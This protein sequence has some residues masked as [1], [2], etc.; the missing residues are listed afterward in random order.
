MH[1]IDVRKVTTCFVIF[2]IL[3]KH[4]VI[5]TPRV[6]PS[7]APH[8]NREL[9][10]LK[11]SINYLLCMHYAACMPYQRW[12]ILCAQKVF[13]SYDDSNLCCWEDTHTRLMRISSRGIRQSPLCAA[14]S[15]ARSL[16]GFDLIDLISAEEEKQV[17]LSD[18]NN[19]CFH[20]IESTV[21]Y[22]E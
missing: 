9:K 19:T 2:A 10:I 13:Q 20:T 5:F 17:V 22:K 11:N 3:C 15:R 8:A 16:W 1:H 4:R 7:R 12:L 21:E 6:R 18:H 14:I